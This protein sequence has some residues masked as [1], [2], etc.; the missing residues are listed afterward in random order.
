VGL[1]L[2]CTTIHLAVAG[3]TLIFKMTAA[4][5]SSKTSP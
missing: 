5:T 1:N 3:Q 4:M 2:S